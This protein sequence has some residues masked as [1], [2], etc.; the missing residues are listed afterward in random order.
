MLVIVAPNTYA[1]ALNDTG[2]TECA[3]D[4][5]NNLPCPV[6]G[7]PGQDAQQGRDAAWK[8]GKLQKIGGGRDGFDYT[9][10]SGGACVRDNVTG[11]VWENKTDDGGLQD[12][13]NT[14]SWYNPNPN[15]NGGDS[16]TQQGG[17]CFGSACDTYAYCKAVNA[18]ALCGFNDWRLPTK[19]E[20]LSLINRGIPSTIGP[21]I[22]TN[23]FP[24]TRE[25]WF[26][27]GSPNAINSGNAW[28]VG[29]FG[30]GNYNGDKNYD[31]FSVRL[32]RGGQ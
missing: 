9:L 14:Y 32:V 18:I 21:S 7:F 5:N 15:T 13:D 8:A 12:A 28:A 25:T 24:N 3:D 1:D 10:L 27:S 17:D 30:G 20:L 2:I 29:F 22:D 6:A 16:G 26:W 11:L 4:S 19:K 31:F 23:Y